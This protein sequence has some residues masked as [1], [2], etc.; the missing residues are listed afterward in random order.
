MK[1]KTIMRFPLTADR[2]LIIKKTIN[3]NKIWQGGHD[4]R[5][6]QGLES[7]IIYLLWKLAWRFPKELNLDLPYELAIPLLDINPKKPLS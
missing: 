5:T 7:K 1:I 6:H 4:G 2:M 3:C